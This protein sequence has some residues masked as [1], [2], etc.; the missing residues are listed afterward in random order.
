MKPASNYRV[1]VVS[2]LHLYCR[3][4]RWQ[5]LLG[6]VDAAATRARVFVFNGDTL[7]FKWTQ[8]GSAAATVEA[9]T[10]YLTGF[11]ERHAHCRIHLNLGNHDHHALFMDALERIAATYPHFSWDPFL[12]RHANLVCLHGDAA[13]FG[14]RQQ[15]LERYRASWLEKQPA[16]EALNR[17]HDWGFH[18]RIQHILPA[19]VFPEAKT[20]SRLSAYLEAT[21]CSAADGVD[22]VCYGHAHRPVAGVLYRGQRF[23][24]GGAAMRGLPFRVLELDSRG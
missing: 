10:A 19:V 22:T 12:F 18:A 13:H 15:H 5:A 16:G 4:S 9:G 14:P 23:H 6:E 24:N 1:C 11:L 8:L 3:R 21:A 7:D 17:L 20:L 2:D